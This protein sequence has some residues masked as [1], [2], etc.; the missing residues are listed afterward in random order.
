MEAGAGGSSPCES[1]GY[2]D[3]GEGVGCDKDG[4]CVKEE[5]CATG[6][7]DTGPA[8]DG[9]A[10]VA[11]LDFIQ[12][13]KV[14]A[15]DEQHVE[16]ETALLQLTEDPTTANLKAVLKV[17]GVHFTTEEGL[18]D[19]HLYQGVTGG[20]SD[21]GFNADASA[22]RSHWADHARMI[23]QIQTQVAELEADAMMEGADLWDPEVKVAVPATFVNRV[24]RDFENHANVYDAA[25]AERLSA[26]LEPEEAD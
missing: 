25:Y 6:C 5:G 23:G 26:A 15:L 21:G 12:S 10:A 16:C 4:G 8:E 20:S 1:D 22:R 24:L 19:A 14:D 17:Y 9:P 11:P 3:S 7:C 18:L 2:D 13:V